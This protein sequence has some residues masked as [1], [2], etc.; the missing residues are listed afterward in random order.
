M[1]HDLSLKDLSEMKSAIQK[2]IDQ[3]DNH[4][5][6]ADIYEVRGENLVSKNDDF[7]S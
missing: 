3:N 2:K 5:M 4:S 1:N 6:L 7:D